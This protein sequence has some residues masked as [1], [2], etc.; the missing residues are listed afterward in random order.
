MGSTLENPDNL[1]SKMLRF[2]FANLDGLQMLLAVV[3][4]RCQLHLLMSF[5]ESNEE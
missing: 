2:F 5:R 3:G 4:Q 1:M